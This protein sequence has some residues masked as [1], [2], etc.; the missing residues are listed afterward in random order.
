M[1]DHSAHIRRLPPDFGLD[2]G[3][4]LHGNRLLLTRIFLAHALDHTQAVRQE[5]K[6][7][8]AILACVLLFDI[9][10]TGGII[11]V[12]LGSPHD[13]QIRRARLQ[14]V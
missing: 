10:G 4:D 14:P 2:A 7:P 11:W 6:A 9:L 13:D 1:S 12:C 3:G 8:S 5:K